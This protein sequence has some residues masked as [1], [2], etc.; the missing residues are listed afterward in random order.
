MALRTSADYTHESLFGCGSLICD[1]AAIERACH[2]HSTSGARASFSAWRG[3]RAAVIQRRSDIRPL[4][5]RYLLGMPD[6]EQL[7]LAVTRVAEVGS[8]TWLGKILPIVAGRAH[9]AARWPAI[10]RLI[11]IDHYKLITTN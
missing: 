3:K 8:K 1:I 4:F 10:Q 5:V 7:A 6:S 2:A 9:I 11:Q